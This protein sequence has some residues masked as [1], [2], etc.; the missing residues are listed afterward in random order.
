MKILCIVLFF[1]GLTVLILQSYFKRKE[2]KTCK[3]I[4]S[5]TRRLFRETN[6]IYIPCTS[7][8]NHPLENN[9]VLLVDTGATTNFIRQSIIQY[10]YPDYNKH[11]LYGDD[12]MSVNGTMTLNKMLDIPICIG[13]NL[14]CQIE[15]TLLEHTESLDYLS[16][17]CE[18]YVVGIV[19]TEFLKKH[20][21]DIKFSML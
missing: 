3:F 7:L 20:N 1:V 4:T 2:F 18:C 19:G 5:L 21:I 17:E 10:V 6:L 9:S 15:A 16:K 11:I 13:E 8:Y 14:N 12:V